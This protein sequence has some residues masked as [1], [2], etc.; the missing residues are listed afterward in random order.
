MNLLKPV[1]IFL[2]GYFVI[3]N[4]QKYKKKIKQISLVGNELYRLTEKNRDIMLLF[5][6]S[7]ISYLI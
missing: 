5:I 7:L 6:I 2:V 1:I 3:N 4:Y